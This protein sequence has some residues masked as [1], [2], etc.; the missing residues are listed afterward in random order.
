[1]EQAVWLAF[2]VIAFILGI[3]ILAEIISS[4]G[5]ES[6]VEDFKEAMDRL[7]QQCDFVCDANLDTYLSADVQLSSGLLLNTAGQRLCGNLNISGE[8]TDKCVLCACPVSMK[9][10]LNLQTDI[11]RNS[12]K[13]HK[14]S[15]YF[16]RRENDVEMECKG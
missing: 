13:S 5:E 12:F 2:G 6:R 10:P 14:Y 11:A 16:L 8:A 9:E 7:K 4:S 3:G 1:M 15:C